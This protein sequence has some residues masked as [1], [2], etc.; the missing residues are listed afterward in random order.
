MRGS[1]KSFCPGTS[2]ELDGDLPHRDPQKCLAAANT[3]AGDPGSP[4]N[5]SK[6]AGG[7]VVL[8]TW[9]VAVA[10]LDRQRGEG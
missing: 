1:R 10:V 6:V 9:R 8:A 4:A 3:G 7:P 2:P 5:T